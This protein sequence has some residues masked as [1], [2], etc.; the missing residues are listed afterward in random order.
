MSLSD[1]I[2]PLLE[3]LLFGLSHHHLPVWFLLCLY[4]DFDVQLIRA[5]T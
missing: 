4:P 3:I 5:S 1:L 2:R